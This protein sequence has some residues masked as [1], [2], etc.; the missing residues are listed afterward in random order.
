VPFGASF[1]FH[2]LSK[3]SSG[4][5]EIGSSRQEGDLLHDEC[6]IDS[7]DIDTGHS[8]VLESIEA[9]DV[10]WK[11]RVARGCECP[12]NTNLKIP[13]DVRYTFINY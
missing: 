11:V 10:R 5:S 13:G 4:S 3:D 2:A 7:E 8:F 9:F 12:R 6:I 1:S